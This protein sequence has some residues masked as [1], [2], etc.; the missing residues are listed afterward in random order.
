MI[1]DSL[2]I[3][4]IGGSNGGGIFTS[5]SV[6]NVMNSTISGNKTFESRAHGGGIY[7]SE[8]DVFLNNAQVEDN[9]VYGSGSEG[10]GIFVNEGSLNLTNSSVTDGSAN[11]DGGGIRVDDSFLAPTNSSLTL[12]ESTVS[13]NFTTG[14]ASRGGGISAGGEASVLLEASTVSNNGT[15][16]TNSGGGGISTTNG[17]VVVLSSTISG[18]STDGSF[19]GGGGIRTST[20]D[21]TL[22]NSSVSANSTSELSSSGG[23]IDAGQGDF[24][25]SNSTIS[26]NVALRGDG[27]GIFSFSGTVTL[28]S[29]T[30]SGNL[31]LEGGGV[32]ARG[33]VLTLTDST[34]SV[35]VAAAGGG[36]VV[37][38]PL[39]TVSPANFQNSIVAGNSDNGS[40]PDVRLDADK[41]LAINHSMIGVADG[42]TLVGDSY[43]TGTVLIP[44][45][46]VLGP[47]ADNGGPTQTHA[48]LPG[49]PAF[50]AG[51]STMAF[52]QRGVPRERI[53]A[54]D[55]GAYEVEATFPSQGLVVSTLGDVVD[56]VFA[57]GELSLREAVSLANELDGDN[58]IT[59]DD[60][61]SGQTI[62]LS[63]VELIITDTVDI[64]ASA[65]AAPVAID[66]QQNSRVLHF[67][68]G[69]ID[70]SLSHLV[71]QNGRT[72]GALGHG[73]GIYFSASGNLEINSSVI[74]DNSILGQ[75]AGGG[76][77]LAPI[78]IGTKTLFDT[79]VTGNTSDGS[80]GG[81][82]AFFS[83]L[84]ITDSLISGN[85]SGDSVVPGLNKY[86]GGLYVD[87]GEVTIS[88]STISE[89]TN[90]SLYGDGGGI[91][92]HRGELTMTDS[93]VNG[94]RIEGFSSDGAGI[95]A[96]NSDVTLTRSSVSGNRFSDPDLLIPQ[97]GA[98]FWSSGGTL[99]LNNTSVRRNEGN[100]VVA[101]YSTL[102]IDDSVI[103]ENVRSGIS[104]IGTSLLLTNTTV[105]NNTN[106]DYE[107]NGVPGV[108]PG[109]GIDFLGSTLSL[110]N[111]TVTGNESTGVNAPYTD[112]SNLGPST[113]HIRNSI[114][115]GNLDQGLPRDIALE[116]EDT[117][118]IN[119]S[120]IG[121]ADDLGTI[122]GNVGNLT[123]TGTSPLDP[124]LGP[125]SDNGGPT[126]THAL[127]SGS[128]ALDAGD[129]AFD[130]N[131]NKFD[132]RGDGFPRIRG[133]VIDIGA[134]EN[135]FGDPP[136]WQS[137]TRHAPL[138]E[139]TA[140]DTLAFRMSFS[141]QVQNLDTSDF[142]ITGMSTARITNLVPVQGTGETMFQVT[143]AG[144]DLDLF[145]G[146]VGIGLASTND[147]SDLDGNLL[148]Q[149]SP[150][151]NE[152]FTLDNVAPTVE[153][154]EVG[155][156]QNSVVRF[157][158]IT[159]DSQV[160]I[161]K[162]AFD[163]K[164]Q[165]DI[166][167]KVDSEIT[168]D[169]G[170]TRVE[171]TFS[172]DLVESGG[173]L[174][175]GNYILRILDTHVKDVAG[176]LLD[177]DNDGVA[178]GV[179]VDEFFRFF[180]DSDQ[181][182]DVDGQDYGRFGLAFLKSDGTPGF[183]PNF[184]F[185]NDGD[186]DGQDYGQFGIR[187]LLSLD[188]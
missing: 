74:R 87:E 123:G 159:F 24:T 60:T 137:V 119:H 184:D 186:V 121:V 138:D 69:D 178:G 85:S 169:E 173:S 58:Y 132:Q 13:G 102:T 80:G 182:R 98:G 155:D 172:G 91:A 100:G 147:I 42:L 14:S 111:S 122:G 20:G 79:T 112:I 5:A 165:D 27:G 54:T 7:S 32:H 110:L 31:G 61:L 26:D 167:V 128:P 164:N 176:N 115:A 46:P 35:N 15:S 154:I 23:G 83:N 84:T 6:L 12:T 144:G 73:A 107:F 140:F 152:T 50:N 81:I 77:A 153:S 117:L 36:V 141:E 47:L 163:L 129:P 131:T 64:D 130:T 51:S 86:G 145:N 101:R 188:P 66:A 171:L 166:A 76:I 65:L 28:Q 59:F 170:K 104:A 187:F 41:E 17:N 44:L 127:L 106:Q 162:D 34:V 113:I 45:A 56:G 16:G 183:D 89:N 126:L 151:L 25:A 11:G 124:M 134:F 67:V 92:V 177:G 40:A 52:D 95:S 160:V 146:L 109:Y 75:A 114:V 142:E 136:I 148:Y 37:N 30:V 72:T 174:S 4:N 62:L 82:A 53:G 49:S 2:I 57:P 125:L 150:T 10:G 156:G 180:G 63:G 133:G 139:I 105:S 185:D 161:A 143:I 68:G 18:N 39:S 38:H 94:N 48:L 88:G 158:A 78:G 108:S 55:M 43:L 118:T 29:S 103:S 175:D 3:D 99:T 96:F 1:H 120:L 168:F 93:T 22:Q 21:V 71:V 19:S 157:I 116:P 8:N 33:G 90:W 97:S 179:A 9:H 149:A 70:L 135:A 181:D